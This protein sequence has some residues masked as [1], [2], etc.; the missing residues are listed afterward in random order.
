ML[1]LLHLDLVGHAVLLHPEE[2]LGLVDEHRGW[3]SL[4][5]LERRLQ[6]LKPV[7]KD[8]VLDEVLLELNLVL[9][10]RFEVVLQRLEPMADSEALAICQEASS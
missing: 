8:V 5:K 7:I 10:A 2:V 4:E 6:V 3:K 9:P 1:R